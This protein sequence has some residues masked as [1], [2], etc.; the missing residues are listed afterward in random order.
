MITLCISLQAVGKEK[1]A[2]DL[3]ELDWK[4]RVLIFLLFKINNFTNI[5]N[6]RYHSLTLVDG[7]K[8][9]IT[10]YSCLNIK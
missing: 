10:P 2:L 5:N 7:N 4:N 6:R 1:R 3:L 9:K 8:N